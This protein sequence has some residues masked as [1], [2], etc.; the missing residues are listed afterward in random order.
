MTLYKFIFVFLLSFTLLFNTEVYSQTK[1]DTAFHYKNTSVGSDINIFYKTGLKL[2][3]APA[4]F[5]GKDWLITG[6]V[7]A[8]TGLAFFAD[9]DVREF[10][11]GISPIPLQTF[12]R[13]E[14]SMVMQAL[15]QHLPDL[16]ISVENSS[17]I[18]KL[19]LPAECLS[20]EF[21]MPDLQTQL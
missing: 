15:Q 1:Q 8:A 6:S 12:F 10:G 7:L 2:Y 9:E 18:L 19:Q 3:S 16:F 4:H 13:S 17:K 21:F 20:K 11:K 14:Q 5:S